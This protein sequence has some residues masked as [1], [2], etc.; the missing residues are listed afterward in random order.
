MAAIGVIGLPL[1]LG[2]QLALAWFVHREAGAHRR[3]SPL[4]LAGTAFALAHVLLLTSGSLLT[5]LLIQF[6]LVCLYLVVDLA[7]ERRLARAR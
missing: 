6:V 7:V 5:V 4:V 3:R 2:T 1:W